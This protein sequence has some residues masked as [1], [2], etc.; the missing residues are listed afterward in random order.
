MRPP[1]DAAARA[2]DEDVPFHEDAERLVLEPGCD[3]CPGPAAPRE[4]IA[5][6]SGDL[7]ARAFVVG[8][9]P[10][11]G[12]PDAERWRGGNWT[13]R[14]FTTRH[15]GRR[16]R[17]LLQTA[18]LLEDAFFTNA[19]KCLPPAD[20]GAPT[21]DGDGSV[22]TDDGGASTNDR[23]TSTDEATVEARE[24]TERER[25][26]CRVHLRAELDAVAPEV[27]VSAG[28]HATASVFALADRDLEG[29]LD[30]VLSV[31]RFDDLPPIVPVL[32]PSYRDV[33]AARLGYEDGDAYEAAVA[34][35][36]WYVLDDVSHDCEDR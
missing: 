33:W 27:I 2:A 19:V 31:H 30:S 4:C 26:N 12:E 21:D 22:P 1:D 14:A 11:T 35:V 17:R 16:I 36:L 25:A 18:G 9:A 15:S 24:P 20:G 32:H 10:G 23:G 8:E 3:R 28:K 5:W 13:G 29:F 6:G 7:D 34:E